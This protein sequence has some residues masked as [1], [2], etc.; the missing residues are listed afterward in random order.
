MDVFYMFGR[1]R[2]KGTCKTHPRVSHVWQGE[3]GREC[4]KHA[5]MDVFYMFSRVG[6]EENT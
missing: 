2:G 4:I 5:Q 6:E 1:V 3:G